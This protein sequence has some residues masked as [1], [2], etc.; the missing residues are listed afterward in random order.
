MSLLQLTSRYMIDE[1]ETEKAEYQKL[2]KSY[3]NSPAYQG[4][5]QAKGR[6]EAIELENK[7]SERDDS[8]MR[9]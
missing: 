6:A 9:H 7:A 2:L 1:Y 4:Y 3:H 5:L 8:I